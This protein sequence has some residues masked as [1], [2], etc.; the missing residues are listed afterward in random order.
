M[1]FQCAIKMANALMTSGDGAVRTMSWWCRS[2]R[3]G[4]GNPVNGFREV[5]KRDFDEPSSMKNHCSINSCLHRQRVQYIRREEMT[6]IH[7]HLLS[8]SPAK[9]I[10]ISASSN[11]ATHFDRNAVLQVTISPYSNCIINHCCVQITTITTSLVN[12][13]LHHSL[14]K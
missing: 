2:E 10:I 3:E 14:N 11:L 4:A 1:T 6:V 7:P 9:H 12:V 5:T 8:R 13:T